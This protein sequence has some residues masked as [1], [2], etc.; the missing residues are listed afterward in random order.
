MKKVK[1]KYYCLK[2]ERELE[3]SAIGS[4]DA[5]AS[6]FTP[7]PMY[8]KNKKCEHFGVVVLAGIVRK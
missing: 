4:M 2:C 6:F 8:C 3:K 1:S 5:L 7:Q